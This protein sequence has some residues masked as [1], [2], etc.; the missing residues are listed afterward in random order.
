MLEITAKDTHCGHQP[1]EGDWR[2]SE[3]VNKSKTPVRSKMF[4]PLNSNSDM[5]NKRDLKMRGPR[6]VYSRI[7]KYYGHKGSPGN[8]Q[9]LRLWKIPGSTFQQS[10]F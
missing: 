5:P 3:T 4:T 10:Q 9:S 7:D 6:F 1:D 2:V 8:I